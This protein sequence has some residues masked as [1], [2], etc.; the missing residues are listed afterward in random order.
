MGLLLML[1][2][3]WGD[4]FSQLSLAHGLRK[5]IFAFGRITKECGFCPPKRTCSSIG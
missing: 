2:V 1:L 3:R 5:A 4:N